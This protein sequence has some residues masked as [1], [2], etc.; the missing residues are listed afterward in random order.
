VKFK[1]Y[2]ALIADDRGFVAIPRFQWVIRKNSRSTAREEAIA[3]KVIE[4]AN[5]RENITGHYPWGPEEQM[6]LQQLWIHPENELVEWRDVPTTGS[7]DLYSVEQ[8]ERGDLPVP[9][10]VQTPGTVQGDFKQRLRDVLGE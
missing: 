10:S 2:M 6:V 1:D 5:P 8:T 9:T 7:K 3:A 4:M